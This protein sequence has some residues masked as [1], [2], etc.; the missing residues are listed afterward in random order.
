[1]SLSLPE[2]DYCPARRVLYAELPSSVRPYRTIRRADTRWHGAT[3]EGLGSISP[4]CLSG[5]P[6]AI[7]LSSLRGVRT[8]YDEDSGNSSCD[9]PGLSIPRWQLTV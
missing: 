3:P 5:M 8:S 2:F 7:C 4:A 9:R 6:H 1:M